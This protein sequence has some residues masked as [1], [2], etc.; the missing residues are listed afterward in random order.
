M[1][2]LPTP[3]PLQACRCPHAPFSRSLFAQAASAFSRRGFLET[4]MGAALGA[5]L[6]PNRVLAAERVTI[7][8]AARLFDGT[9]MREPGVLVVKGARIASLNA[10]DAGTGASVVDLGDATIMPG[11]IDCHT[12]LAARVS[13]SIYLDG[14][15]PAGESSSSVAEAAILSIKNAAAVLHNGFTTVRDVGGGSGIDLAL[16]DAINSGEI[17]GPRMLVAGVPLSITGG[18]GDTN[19]VPPD[20]IVNRST[21]VS[22]GPYGFRE[23]VRQN[24]KNHVDLIKILATG[25]VLSY[26]DTWNVPQMDLDEIQA[27]VDE[28]HKFGRK[29][30]AHC[31]GDPGI[32]LAVEGGC[33]SIDHCTGVEEKTVQKMKDRGVYLVPTIW[34]LDSINQPGNPN[35]IPENS[36]E[37][38]RR[39]TTLRNEGV[40]RALA[41][42][43][44][45]AYGTD[46]GV[47]PHR[48]NNRDFVRLRALGM[49]PLDMLRSATSAAA[50]N[51]GMSD[52]GRLANGLLADIIA[53]PGNP[54]KAAEAMER[55]SFIMLGGKQIRA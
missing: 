5:L 9:A 52:R 46:A 22:W 35:H 48:E 53:V 11:L 10:G 2:F 39:I 44:R 38:A 37:K 23:V 42:G 28:A 14:F 13:T 36:L 4:A 43:V 6:L 45:M 55:P 51:I 54:A 25:G 31:H 40:Q 18:H 3:H 16:R 15:G 41:G 12:H 21:G 34:A 7:L 1:P 26:G 24:V 47:F 30:T 33:D 17:V 20:V 27:S 29:I 19:D 49:D 8:R 50:E 32:A